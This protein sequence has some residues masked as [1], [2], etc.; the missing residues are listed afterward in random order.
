MHPESDACVPGYRISTSASPH[1][2]NTADTSTVLHST[3]AGEETPFPTLDDF[4]LTFMQQTGPGIIGKWIWRC[5]A[6]DTVPLHVIVYH[7]LGNRYCHRIKRHHKSNQVMYEVN[8]NTG[9]MHQKCWDPDCRGYKSPS[10]CIPVEVLPDIGKVIGLS[11][12]IA[13]ARTEPD[14]IV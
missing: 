10:I 11:L 14:D 5:F 7:I 8:V 2:R 6:N 4:I 12:D 13:I 3:H 9:V 1:S